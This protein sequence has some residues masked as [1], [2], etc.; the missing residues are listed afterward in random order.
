M[1]EVARRP[2]HALREVYRTLDTPG[3][4][5]LKTVHA[6]LDKAVREAYGMG[7][8]Q[9]PLL[10]L[11]DLNESVS[12]TWEARAQPADI[13]PTA[14]HSLQGHFAAFARVR[15]DPAAS[16]FRQRDAFCSPASADLT[17]EVRLDEGKTSV[18]HKGRGGGSKSDGSTSKRPGSALSGERKGS[19]MRLKPTAIWG[20]SVKIRG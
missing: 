7:K 20:M 4:S 9:D 1:L 15:A 14:L 12:G 10:F 3:S 13:C 18:F 19:R 6:D 16:L 17:A 2:C 8:S 5:P 11:L